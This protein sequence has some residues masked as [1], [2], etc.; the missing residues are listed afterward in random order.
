MGVFG[1]LVVFSCHVPTEGGIEAEA[2][3][4]TAPRA[5]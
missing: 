5:N 2:E 3:G 1:L 4:T